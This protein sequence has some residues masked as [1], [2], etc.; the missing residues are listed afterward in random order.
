MGEDIIVSVVENV[1]GGDVLPLIDV[2]KGKKNVSEFTL[3]EELKE[4]INSIRNKLYRLY[5]SNLVEFTRK[6][7]KKKGWYIYYWTFVPSRI[8]H[9]LKDIKRRQLEKVKERLVKEQN[10]HYFTCPDKCMRQTFDQ[11]MDHQFKCPECGQLMNQEDTSQKVE[12]MIKEIEQLTTEMEQEIEISFPEAT[13]DELAMLEKD[14]PEEVA[15]IET[16]AKSLPKEV[17]KKEKPVKVKKEK[18]APKKEVKKKADSKKK[19]V[20]KAKKK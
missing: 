16:V 9:L 3:A 8:P 1:A 11:S 20:K 10:S 2:L 5:D 18:V 19:V 7:D 13:Y 17:I 6:K 4:E 12:L 14:E 15:E